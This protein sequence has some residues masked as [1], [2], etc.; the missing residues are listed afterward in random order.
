ML[1]SNIYRLTGNVHSCTHTHT[2]THTYKHTHTY[3]RTHT[4]THEHRNT[5]TQTRTHAHTHS[6]TMQVYVQQ[7]N[8]YTWQATYVLTQRTFSG[9]IT[10]PGPLL[11][12]IIKPQATYKLVI[13]TKIFHYCMECV[14]HTRWF[15]HL[16]GV[17]AW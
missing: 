4:H 16:E 14:L 6:G 10:W 11:P 13:L 12:L 17:V 8:V 15:H 5:H 9:L 7:R 1:V 2:H 3:I